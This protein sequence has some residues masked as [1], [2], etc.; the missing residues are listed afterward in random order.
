MFPHHE[1]EIAQSNCAGDRF[2]TIWMHNEMLQVEGRKMSKSLGNFF[3]VRDLLDQGWPGEVI[4]MVFLGTHYRKP[5]DWTE[6]KADEAQAT[7]RKWRELVRDVD[8]ASEWGRQYFEKSHGPETAERWDVVGAIA[9]DLN[10]PLALQRVRTL[11]G[12][13]ERGGAQER[14]WLKATAAFLG[15]LTDDLGGWDEAPDTREAGPLI[16][17]L[18][19]DRLAARQVRD[20]DRAD[21]LRDGIAGAG[22]IIM[23]TPEGPTWR[24]GPDFDPAKLEAL[25]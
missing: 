14:S 24:L 9:E 22:V 16:D 5:M 23:D 7:L 19:A 15:L 10:T 12:I 20:F 21:A 17:A 4:R 8:F 2:A 1:N 13:A 11:A 6:E 25:R 3:T 18:L